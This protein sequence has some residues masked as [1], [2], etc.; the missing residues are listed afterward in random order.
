MR[1]RHASYIGQRTGELPAEVTGFVG[2]TRELGDLS[3]LLGRKRMITL[4][5]PGGVG[6]TRLA[7]RAAGAARRRFTNGVRLVE[8]TGLHDPE[9]LPHT[10][11]AA[12]GLAEQ[13]DRDQLGLLVD[14]LARKQLLLIL[15]TCE[16]LLDACAMLTDL[17]LRMAPRV[18]VLATSRQPLDVPGELAYPVAPLP[19][20]HEAV[21]LFVERAADAVPGFT[22]TDR[23][24]A[25][26]LAVCRRLDG[27][28]LAIELAVVRLRVLPLTELAA[29]LEHR[30]EALTG[31]RRSA[32]PRHQTLRAAIDWSHD[33]CTV[34]EQLLWRRLSLFAGDFDVR[35]AED[36]CGG[37]PLSAEDVLEHLIGLVDK[38]VVLRT[39][40]EHA[41]YRL[42]DTLRE[43]GAERLAADGEEETYRERHFAHFAALAR[44]AV[45][46]FGGDE[47]AGRLTA[48]DRQ[49]PNLRL[50]LEYGT[51]PAAEEA[52]T[53]LR[54]LT[55]AADL[56]AHWITA[57]RLREGAQ[58]LRRGL[59]RVRHDC[60]EAVEALH[61]LAWVLMVQGLHDEAEPQVLASLAMAERIGDERGTAHAIQFRG[62]LTMI[63]GEAE[64]AHVDLDEA[65]RRLRALGD[66]DALGVACFIQTFGAAVT[67][68]VARA[69][70]VS[71][72]GLDA[73]RDAPGECWIRSYCLLYRQLALWMA[74]D[75]SRAEER[76]RLGH[77]VL[78]LKRAVG[79]RLG[80]GIALELLAWSA[81]A[82]GRSERAAWLLGAAAELWEKIGGAR[83]N[84]EVLHAE[85]RA[86]VAAARRAL[87]EEQY[88][89]QHARGRA[90]DLTQAVT[91]ALDDIDLLPEPAP[92]QPP[93]ASAQPAGW[94]QQPT[95]APSV[96]HLDQLTRRE[97]E[98]AALITKGLTNREIADHLVISKRTADAHVEH[99]RTK[100]G[101]T[102][103]AQ[104]AALAPE[105]SPEG[106]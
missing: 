73:L 71:T 16:H 23:N 82:S 12:L 1:S 44:Q 11:A 40:E 95:A 38:S 19:T 47:Q 86:A 13:G 2:R 24:R 49:L 92:R 88:A 68:D 72:E 83:L 77:R 18:T 28:P 5:G 15:D 59:E 43:Y 31:G 75:T 57:G 55:L 42:L 7:V 41:R 52:G 81:A 93:V 104:I 105:T 10:V 34:Q 85:H 96:P 29:R 8:L 53:A 36:V 62:C 6:K 33:L 106:G 102:S 25:E 65:R 51:G 58:W 50:A 78:E 22:L 89:E 99:I 90:L 103:R 69:W 74:R 80:T 9:L 61:R 35:A 14:H 32:L 30:F 46:P 91:S 84:A 26:M 97:R 54:G 27:M 79:D 94:P 56:W 20:D 101:F 67:G 45:D 100:L 64:R 48:L 39:N 17:L 60:P 37:G 70:E 66:R 3:D 63:R 98:V 76:D 21:Q 87:T 4:V